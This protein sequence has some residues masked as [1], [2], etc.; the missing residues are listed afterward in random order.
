V[1]VEIDLET[2]VRELSAEFHAR[3]NAYQDALDVGDVYKD[4]DAAEHRLMAS[5]LRQIANGVA[6]AAKR[7]E[8]KTASVAEWANQDK[9]P[10]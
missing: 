4:D 1:I 3:A 7:S 9:T 10:P 2:F 5:L 6:S 8:S